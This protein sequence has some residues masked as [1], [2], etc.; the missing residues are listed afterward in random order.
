M[1]MSK[2]QHV[3]TFLPRKRRG[4][5]SRAFYG[6]QGKFDHDGRGLDRYLGD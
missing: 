3:I 2:K 5:I 6:D 4:L 1:Q